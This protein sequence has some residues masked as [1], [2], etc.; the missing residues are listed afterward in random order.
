M[1]SEDLKNSNDELK[2]TPQEGDAANAPELN[3][4]NHT[5]EK[6]ET[7]DDPVV[8]ESKAETDPAE[9]QTVENEAEPEAEEETIEE[10]KAPEAEEEIVAEEPKT[11][12]V[13]SEE[14]KE[15]AATETVAEE[16]PKEKEERA[17]IDYSTLTEVELINAMRDLLDNH[18]EEDIK[19]DVDS[20]KLNFYKRHRAQADEEKKKFV[21]DG[22]AEEDFE[23]SN[24]PY[25]DDLRNLL[26]EFRQIRNK[27][28]RE[29]EDEKEDNLQRKYEIIEEIKNLVNR[30]ESINKT[31]QE[32]RELQQEWREIGLVPQSKLKDLWET[33][34]HHVENFYDY[35]KINRELRD[36]DLKKNMEAK[37]NLCEKAEELL[38]E[39]SVI[40]A[41]NILQKYHEQWREIGPVPRD[42]KEELWERFK[43]ATSKI[44]K[45]H[46]AYFEGRKQEQKKN[47][48]AKTV[49]C[50]K[51]EE[52]ANHE[53]KNHKDWDKKSRELIELQK[54][55]RTIGFAP[56]KDNNRI[57]ERFRSACDKF[58]DAKREFYAQNKELQTNNLQLKTDLCVQAEALKDS[59]DWRK[60]TEEFIHIQKKWKEI[61]PVPR[62]HSDAIWKR[63]RAACDFF[64]DNKSEHFHHVDEEQVENL[65]LKKDLIEEVKNF[66]PS[67]DDEADLQQIKEFQRRWTDIGYVPFKEK[68][69]IQNEFRDA[70]NEHFDSL[71]IDEQKRNLLRF[72]TKM[73][74]ISGSTRGN[75]KMRYERDKY[76]NKLK[77]LENDLILL[78]NNVGF[79]ANTKNAESLIDDVNRKIQETKEKIEFL[80]EKIRIIDSM[81]D[82]D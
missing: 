16:Q 81:E 71:K 37:I 70:I 1:K 82:E 46:Q 43:A 34:H 50:E 65:Q 26:K 78:N 2:A 23:A 79:F 13:E 44:N 41:F 6:T 51:A 67:K 64:F 61:G 12:E 7:S 33:Y 30:K 48:E 75:N 72:K 11:P 3:P 55:W 5:E 47:L 29:Q 56:K 49:L 38:V 69:V 80:K 18:A 58:F 74:N 60:T 36:L 35:I 40:K 22:G 57:Y 32:F 19:A 45:K 27:Q 15:P 66:E 39:P 25:E 42:K 10:E 14:P 68:D 31:F 62:K 28:H 8:E 52:I 76:V 24:T 63:F 20:I 9:E 73:S 53:I 77:Q 59:T 17:P 4:E 21:E 54:V